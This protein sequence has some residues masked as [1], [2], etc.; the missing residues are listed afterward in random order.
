MNSLKPQ[1]R[2]LLP[3]LHVACESIGV[4]RHQI[5]ISSPNRVSLPDFGLE[6]LLDETGPTRLWVIRETY[7]LI[8]LINPEGRN[9][10][11][12]VASIPAADHATVAQHIATRVAQQLIEIALDGELTGA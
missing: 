8:S 10:E 1:T 12:I 6:A 4:H 9:V 2:S 7:K 3:L 5:E 11:K